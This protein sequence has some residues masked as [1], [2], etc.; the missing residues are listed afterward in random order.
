ID[1]RLVQEG[2]E[3]QPTRGSGGKRDARGQRG[4][5]DER[6]AREERGRRNDAASPRLE[7]KAR[8]AEAWQGA[9]AQ[10]PGDDGQEQGADWSAGRGSRSKPSLL[11]PSLPPPSPIEGLKASVRKAASGS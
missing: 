6:G 7:R 10:V 5:R 3:V 4:A 8:D 2:G 9:D 1:F 11:M